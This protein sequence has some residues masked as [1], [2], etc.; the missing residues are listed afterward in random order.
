MKILVVIANL[1]VVGAMI[2]VYV[3]HVHA[4]EIDHLIM[5]VQIERAV[6]AALIAQ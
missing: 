6:G 1:I 5:Q 2:V 4:T 3:N